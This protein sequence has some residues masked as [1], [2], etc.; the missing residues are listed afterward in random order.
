M[1]HLIVLVGVIVGA[2]VF[3]SMIAKLLISNQAATSSMP[4][5]KKDYL[6][7]VAERSFFEVLLRAVGNDYHV[8][9][10]VRMEDVL[11]MPKG[12]KN[13]TAWTN[14]VRQKHVDF[15]LCTKD[16]VEPVLVIELDDSSHDRED[17]QTRDANV[18]AIMSEAGLPILHCPAKRGYVVAEIAQTVKEKINGKVLAA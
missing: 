8:F 15:L 16:R 3:I 9:A 2:M 10:K 17:R 6:F 5:K 18:D 13:R 12:T 1:Q 4:Y 7:S 14:K 11:Y